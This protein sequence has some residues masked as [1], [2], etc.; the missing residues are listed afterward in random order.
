MMQGKREEEGE[1]GRE[2]KEQDWGRT[3]AGEGAGDV[4]D[5]WKGRRCKK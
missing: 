2:S 3:L 5:R 1:G 4:G